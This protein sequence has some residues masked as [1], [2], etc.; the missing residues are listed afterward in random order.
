MKANIKAQLCTRWVWLFK[1]IWTTDT[2]LVQAWA[3]NSFIHIYRFKMQEVQEETINS[4]SS[5]SSSST[6]SS[7]EDMSRESIPS[8]RTSQCS[9]SNPSERS[10]REEA[11]ARPLDSAASQKPKQP[12]ASAAA[13][14]KKGKR[15]FVSP[16]PGVSAI[17]Y[18]YISRVW[19]C[20]TRA[21]E[22][23]CRQLNSQEEPNSWWCKSKEAGES[24]TADQVFK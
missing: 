14:K 1:C 21:P 8:E 13:N 19:G 2:V 4:S 15:Q 5:S 10:D 23:S 3:P 24:G 11:K 12:K 17:I 16:C 22:A 7:D 9:D 20:A 6:S 18:M